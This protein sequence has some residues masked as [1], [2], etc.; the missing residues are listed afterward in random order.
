M[1]GAET[2]AFESF[3]TDLT[4]ARFL[5]RPNRFVV[6]AELGD[7]S[8]V[9]AHLPN[10]GRLG[11]ILRPGRL[12]RL[13]AA[14]RDDR[15][16]NWSAVLARTPGDDGWVSLVTTLPN[17]LVGGALEAGALEELAGWSLVRSEATVG[18]S[19][20]D[21]LLEQGDRRLAL[22][23][24]S[25]TLEREGMGLFP[26]AVTERGTRHLRE[27]T[28]L[29]G[30]DGWEAGV[31]FVAQRDDVSSV[32]AAPDIDPTFADALDEAREAGVHVRARRCEVGPAGVGLGPALPVPATR[33]A[34]SPA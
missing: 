21:F 2:A 18:D 17:R 19:R 10:P 14:D 8:E 26:D 16:T 33:E 34:P 9:R 23:V 25:V 28:A 15:K 6:H 7:G 20:L 22:E 13:R 11:A 27:L 24:K 30:R 5:R 12:L 4:P 32:T 29:A 3:D 31:L 1:S